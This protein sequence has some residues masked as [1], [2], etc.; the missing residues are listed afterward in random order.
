MDS[1]SKSKTSKLIVLMHKF[2]VFFPVVLILSLILIIFIGYYFTYL[3]FQ[4]AGGFQY[5]QNPIKYENQ[6]DYYHSKGLFL[7]I[8]MCVTLPLLL[9]SLLRTIFENPGFFP[10]PLDLEYKIIQKHNR[11]LPML[12]SNSLRMEETQ[13]LGEG[14]RQNF[15]SNFNKIVSNGPLTNI[16]NEV[17]RNDIGLV[18]AEDHSKSKDTS[19]VVDYEE[20]QHDVFEAFRNAEL[21]KVMLCGTCLRMKVERSHHCRQCGKCVLKMDHHCPWLANC[22]GFRNYKYF[23]LTHF[24][25]MVGTLVVALSYFESI[26]YFHE[27]EESSLAVCW[28]SLFLYMCNLS[29]MCFLTW[30]IWVNWR[31]V[32]LGQS[33]IESA[34]KERFPSTKSLNVYDLGYYRN[35]CKVFGRNP[36]VWFLPFCP[37]Y[38]EMGYTFESIYNNPSFR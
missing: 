36:L 33:V 22:I 37:N 11:N 2:L 14:N 8:V 30:L 17:L 35:F 16:E 18:L 29:L 19:L 32:F 5:R 7:L 1:K 4:L 25:G 15:L 31:L 38:E 3:E 34:D 26:F 23:C 12:K 20:I 27:A 10:S 24:W 6:K 9:I 28:F 21:S 13:L